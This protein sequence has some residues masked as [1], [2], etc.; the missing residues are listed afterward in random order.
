MGI[1]QRSF[2]S[3]SFEDESIISYFPRNQ[4]FLSLHNLHHEKPFRL[5]SRQYTYSFLEFFAV[6]SLSEFLYTTLPP[7]LIRKSDVD[8]F[9]RGARS[10]FE[11]VRDDSLVL[12]GSEGT[13]RVDE[14]SS[15]FQ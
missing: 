9:E 10:L 13:R 6:L 5:R 11:E 2:Y 14:G 8:R 1:F 15:F 4:T 7:W 3:L 12:L